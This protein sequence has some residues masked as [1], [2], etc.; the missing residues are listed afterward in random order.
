V[1]P[2]RLVDAY[3]LQR[4]AVSARLEGL[5]RVLVDGV[6][7]SLIGYAAAS[8]LGILVQTLTIRQLGVER[9]GEYVLL[10][11]LLGLIGSALGLGLDS[12]L[13][14][15]GGSHPERL[16]HD[17]Y[18]VLLLKTLG[19]GLLVAALAIGWSNHLV[20]TAA[21]LVGVVGTVL[22]S[23]AQT[24]YTA[25]RARRHNRRVAVFQALEPLLLLAALLLVSS[26][27]QSVLLLVVVRAASA[28]LLFVILMRHIWRLVGP[29]RRIFA[30]LPVLRD[31]WL[32][33]SGDMLAFI[34][35]TAPV[36][37]LGSV[38][39]VA[40]VGLFRPA[41][42]LVTLLF[43]FPTLMFLVALPL[44]SAPDI[45][46]REYL[47]LLYAMVA[48]LALY[49][50]ASSLGLWLFG[51]R[52]LGSLYGQP[53]RAANE[54]LQ[55]LALVPLLKA[56]SFVAAIVMVSRGTIHLRVLAQALVAAG[57]I[58][59]SW[60]LVPVSGAQGAA[61]V[62]L[63]LEALLFCLYCLGAAYTL[64]RHAP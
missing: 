39:G 18:Q 37:I 58:G 32:F 22:S 26:S 6:A 1:S 17:I 38:A 63:A 41:L 54:Y 28:A 36:W 33:G 51:E 25:L 53:F 16:A 49:G 8:L 46:R 57:S 59:L 4:R 5:V 30:P 60:L 61:L 24:G 35:G 45:T 9:Y 13:L 19:A 29:I 47:R 50:L 64:R 52:L 62:V 23:F 56:G 11:N 7:A 42:D 43:A 3:R 15:S 31:A 21:F 40:A 20:Y 55:T 27:E 12:W 44:L 48:A 14:K 34:Y 10:L 2:T